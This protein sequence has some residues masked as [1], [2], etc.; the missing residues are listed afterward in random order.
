MVFGKAKLAI[1]IVAATLTLGAGVASAQGLTASAGAAAA[2]LVPGEAKATRCEEYNAKLAQNL[3]VSIERL[4]EARKQS[5]L[6]LIDERLAAGKITPEQAQQ[7]RDKVNNAPG[8]C[9]RAAERQEQRAKAKI[10]RVE[11]QAVAQK[12]GI[13]ERDLRKELRGGKSLATVAQE[14]GVS[15]DDLKATMRAA[16]KTRLDAA[17]SGGTLTQAQANKALAAFDKRADTLIDRQRGG[18]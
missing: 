11:L 4:Q 15:R 7:A 16:L 17:V 13:S 14:K 18:R 3:G 9:E 5:A 12:L 10:E 6:Q 2:N 1:G 8:G